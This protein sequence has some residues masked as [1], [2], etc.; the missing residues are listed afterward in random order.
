M[1]RLVLMIL[2]ALCCVHLIAIAQDTPTVHHSAISSRYFEQVSAKTESLQEKLDNKTARVLLRFRKQQNRLKKKLYKIDSLAAKSIF[3]AAED[4][5]RN[6]ENNLEQPQT[7]GQYI[8][9]LDTLKTSFKFLNANKGYVNQVKDIDGKLRKGLSGITGLEDKFQKAEEV[10]SFLKSQ[11]EF[12]KEQVSRFGFAKEL[13]NL[14][15]EVY[16]YSQQVKEYKELIK[17]KKKIERKA[18]EL[19][20]KT[21]LFQD[22]MKRNSMLASLFRMPV[23]DPNDP[24]YLQSLSGLQT[25]VQVNQLIQQQVAAGGPNAL[26]E[27][28]N[29]I[30]EAQNQLQ[31]LKEKMMQAGGN[32]SSDDELPDFR[33]NGQ[34]TKTFLQ[35]LEVGTNMQSQKSN[36][37]FPVTSDIGLSAGYK[38]TDKSV[39]GVGAS[40]KIGWGKSFRQISITH[41]GAGLR[42]F[43]DYNL[44][45]TF[46]ISGGFEMNYK[47]AFNKVEELKNLNAWQQSGLIGIS[48]KMSVNM[49]IMKSTKAQLLWDFLSYRQVPRTQPIVF[50]IGYSFTSSN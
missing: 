10:R 29:N 37:F 3:G 18:V 9:F 22:F 11:K 40:Y 44:K 14:N 34:K 32:G 13:R 5:F 23:D 39:I 1:S 20:A 47:S 50:R 26:Q 4:K 33:P 19:L 21:K 35:R 48:K 16:Y 46:W 7:P 17:D 27:V 6:F 2:P 25:R 31:Q 45:K 28:K 43:L 24:T 15:K 42:S 36:A 38:L 8:P 12:L 30:L 49:K 41:Q